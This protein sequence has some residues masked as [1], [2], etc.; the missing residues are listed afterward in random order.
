MEGRYVMY[1]A[2]APFDGNGNGG[3]LVRD[4]SAFRVAVID[5]PYDSLTLSPVLAREPI[6][7]ADS[8]CRAAGSPGVAT[9]RLSWGCLGPA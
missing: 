4:S 7:L 6:N 1:E 8:V 5:G 2:S 3:I 9:A